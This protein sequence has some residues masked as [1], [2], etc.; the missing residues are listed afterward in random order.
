M[1]YTPTTPATAEAYDFGYGKGIEDTLHDLQASYPE[2]KNSDLWA[3]YIEKGA[4][5]TLTPSLV[6]VNGF[7]T[8]DGTY[9]VG[10]ILVFDA[11]ELSEQEWDIAEGLRDNDRFTYINAC[12]TGDIET[13]HDLEAGELA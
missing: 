10:D 7:V 8:P 6:G 13:K 4:R 12:L 11:G 3:E 1:E 5:Y 9:G 2:I